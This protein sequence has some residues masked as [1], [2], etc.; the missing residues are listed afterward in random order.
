MVSK[1]DCSVHHFKLS[2]YFNPHTLS[3]RTQTVARIC[4]DFCPARLRRADSCA[5]FATH[6]AKLKLPNR[7]YFSYTVTVLQLLFSEHSQTLPNG[8]LLAVA[9]IR[10]A[11]RATN[12]APTQAD[13]CVQ[14]S[15]VM[16][17]VTQSFA[18]V[19]ASVCVQTRNCST[20][21]RHVWLSD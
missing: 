8:T 6:A 12:R 10:A 3:G 5:V 14:Q 9:R 15:N 19:H 7:V 21:D 18:C 13:D 17:I 11:N 2:V 1:T 20:V 16:S 4:T